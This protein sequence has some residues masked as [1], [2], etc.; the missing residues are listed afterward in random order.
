M[1]T[2]RL[3]VSF[4]LIGED[5]FLSFLTLAFN[6]A[7]WSFGGKVGFSGLGNPNSPFKTPNK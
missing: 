1:G 2:P 5:K 4:S 7:W 6:L 3:N